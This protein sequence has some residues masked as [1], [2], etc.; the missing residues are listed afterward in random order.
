M[1]PPP[2]VITYRVI[3]VA[4]ATVI[5]VAAGFGLAGRGPLDALGTQLRAASTQTTGTAP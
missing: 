5:L 2:H 4:L 3:T 1:T